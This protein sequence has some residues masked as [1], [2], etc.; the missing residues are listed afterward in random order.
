MFSNSINYSVFK[1]LHVDKEHLLIRLLRPPSLF[2]F[3]TKFETR[4]LFHA[5]QNTCIYWYSTKNSFPTF[6]WKRN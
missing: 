5:I 6:Y 3:L 2:I 1:V 4:P